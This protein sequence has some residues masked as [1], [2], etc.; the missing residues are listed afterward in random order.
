VSTAELIGNCTRLPAELES[1]LVCP[2]CKCRLEIS[3]SECR[4]THPGCGGTYPVRRQVPV[5]INE[6]NSLFTIAGVIRGEDKPFREPPSVLRKCLSQLAPQLSRN[7]TDTAVYE[8]LA[9]ELL[10]LARPARVLVIGSRVEGSGMDL[11]SRHPDIELIESDVELGPRPVVIFDAHDIPFEDETFDGVVVQAVLEHVADPVRCVAEIHRVLRPHGLIYAETPFMQQVHE[12][13]YDYT[14]FTHLG[15]RWLMR[16]F[17]ELAS[18]I[19]CGPG[20]ALAWA[21]RYFLLS[22]AR[23]PL[24]RAVASIAARGTAFWLKYFDS[25][26]AN[27]PGA[28]D[29]ASG[30]Y[31]LGRKS[32]ARLGDRQLVHLYRGAIR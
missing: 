5:L 19:S 10:S 7:V 28:Y 11:L 22:F 24:S 4:C 2:R 16:N 14:R 13:A 18:G 32:L 30:F 20:M 29:A 3:R 21:W 9:S 8:M 6:L 26:L 27:R 31:F 1:L 25:F 17:E 12:G 23:R 15:H